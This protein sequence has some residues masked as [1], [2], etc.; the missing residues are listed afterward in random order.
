M[1]AARVL[2][3]FLLLAGVALRERLVRS[4]PAGARRAGRGSA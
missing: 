3:Y 2:Y 4:A 1:A